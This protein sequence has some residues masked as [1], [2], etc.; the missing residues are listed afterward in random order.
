MDVCRPS[1]KSSEFAE[2][3]SSASPHPSS[4][5]F[6]TFVLDQFCA[7]AMMKLYHAPCRLA[8]ALTPSMRHYAPAVACSCL[9]LLMA[10]APPAALAAESNCPVNDGGG[11]CI[12]YGPCTSTEGDC[13][14]LVTD[15]VARIVAS[16]GGYAPVPDFAYACDK[17]VCYAYF[18]SGP[19]A[20]VPTTDG[21]SGCG[22]AAGQAVVFGNVAPAV[23]PAPAGGV[24][25]PAETPTPDGAPAPAGDAPAPAATP[26]SDPTPTATPTPAAAAAAPTPD[27]TSTATPTPAAAAAATPTP[28]TTPAPA[29]SGGGSGTSCI[30]AKET[31]F[32][33]G[34]ATVALSDLRIGYQVL[35]DRGYLM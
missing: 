19:C 26:A 2:A 29:P 17:S 30:A 8:R 3:C 23:A 12:E 31:V 14:A 20:G 1:R 22:A 24:P 15:S 21:C 9:L 18:L 16:G 25:V 11:C 35:T 7:N 5:P 33:K 32:L 34:G 6:T 13:A 10:V 27:T 4:S 28:D